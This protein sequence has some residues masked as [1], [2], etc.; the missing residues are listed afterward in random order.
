[1]TTSNELETWI[2][3]KLQEEREEDKIYYAICL[4]LA[5]NHRERAELVAS[6]NNYKN[7]LVEN[8][9]HEQATT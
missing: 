3:T 5:I 8:K 4:K 7:E 6:Y 1:M 2:A 9:R